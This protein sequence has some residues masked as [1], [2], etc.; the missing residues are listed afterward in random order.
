MET[1]KNFASKNEAV[2]AYQK[3]KRNYKNGVGKI[4]FDDGNATL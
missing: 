2:D 4:V 3:L 1:P